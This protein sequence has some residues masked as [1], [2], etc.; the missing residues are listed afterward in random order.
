MKTTISGRP[1]NHKIEFPC[2]MI[3]TSDRDIVLLVSQSDS[4]YLVTHLTGPHV[5]YRYEACADALSNAY[6]LFVGELTLQND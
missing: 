6:E 2:L 1:N 4:L 5:N 3:R